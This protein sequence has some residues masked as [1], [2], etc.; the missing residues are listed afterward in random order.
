M[1]SDEYDFRFSCGITK[2]TARFSDKQQIVNAMCLHYSVLVS[3]AELEQL[4]RGLAIQKFNSLMDSYPQLLRKAFQPPQCKITS[5]YIQDLFVAG[6]SPMGSNKRPREEA[7]W[8]CGYVTCSIWKV[9]SLKFVLYDST[10]NFVL[11]SNRSGWS[12]L[13]YAARHYG[14]PDRVWQCTAIRI[15]RCPARHIVYWWCCFANSLDL[16][17]DT[18]FP[19]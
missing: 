14:V 18:L 3:L 9:G 19:T 11:Y 2:P 12:R 10:L 8:W 13:P 7:L 6:F 4:R 17:T 5:E 15:W 1:T 16:L